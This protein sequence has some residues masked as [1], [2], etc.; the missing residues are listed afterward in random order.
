MTKLYENCQ[1][2]IC[3]AFA[4]EMA[5]AYIPLSIDPFEVS[6]AAGT[7]PFGYLPFTPSLGVGGHCIP[8]N[9]YYLLATSKFPLLEAAAYEM[10]NR[11]AMIAE[12][13]LSDLM[14]KGGRRD[15]GLEIEK[16]V[17]VVGIGFKASQSHLVNSPGLKLAQELSKSDLN[18]IFADTLVPQADIPEIP[19]LADK[20]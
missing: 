10:N 2:M 5:N 19:R 7:K 11:P 6:N 18:V 13:I 1:R 3:I 4:N 8:V 12:R 16:N 15:S 14:G 17:L 20:D 9:P